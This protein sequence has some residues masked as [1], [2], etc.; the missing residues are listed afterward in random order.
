MLQKCSVYRNSYYE[1]KQDGGYNLFVMYLN[2]FSME[3]LGELLALATFI[4][5]VFTAENIGSRLSGSLL[6]LDLIC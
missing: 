6:F 4:S 1:N 3:P 5:L 2:G